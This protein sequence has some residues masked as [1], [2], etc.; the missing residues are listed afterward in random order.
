MRPAILDPLFA[1]VSSLAGVGPKLADLLAKLLGRENAEDTRVIDLLFHAPSNIID[2][3]NRPGIAL[4]PQGAIV[5]I[6]G[7]I[8]RHQP[9]PPGNRSAPYRVF[10]HDETGELALTFFRA[11]GDWL[12]KA[13]PVDEEVMVSGKIDWFNG[14]ASMVHP[15]FMVKVSEADN[16]PLVEAV[17]PMTAGLSPKI[18]KR[19]IDTALQRLPVFPEWI[20]E[21]LATRQ[22]FPHVAD[23]FRELHDPRDTVDID[24]QAPARRRLA[25]DEFLAGQLSLALVRQRLRKVAG[26]PIRAKGDY[27][28]RILAGLP[29]SLTASQ[30]AAVKDILTDMAGEDR[31]L[32]LLQGDVGAGKTL[33]ALMAMATAVEAGGQA[34]LMAPTEILARQH[35]A[36][37]T[38]YAAAAGISCE[39]LTGRTKGKERREIEE[40]I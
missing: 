36:T 17:Y 3:R 29:F 11:R 37:M 9:A 19:S 1:T 26:Q 22:S 24:P 14:R 33:V 16:L 10:L 15:D 12:S 7:R 13:L 23:A 18:L 28:A 38:K 30:N 20:D 27:A 32:R 6:Q 2:R 21:T 8:D 4:A 31:M 34:V 39:V 35:F 5:T 40:R 25:Y